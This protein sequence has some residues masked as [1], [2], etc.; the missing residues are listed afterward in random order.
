MGMSIAAQP[1]IYG[2][3]ASWF[4]IPGIALSF[5]EFENF[6]RQ[7]LRLTET[8]RWEVRA[9]ISNVLLGRNQHPTIG[10]SVVA[11]RMY[12]S[13]VLRKY[14]YCLEWQ[15]E[16]SD[17][18]RFLNVKIK[19]AGEQYPAYCA[20]GWVQFKINL[21]ELGRTVMA[22]QSLSQELVESF[23]GY[24]VFDDLQEAEYDCLAWSY[25]KSLARD[26][27]AWAGPEMGDYYDAFVAFVG[28]LITHKRAESFNVHL[29][30]KDGGVWLQVQVHRGGVRLA[31]FT[32]VAEFDEVLI[33]EKQ[34]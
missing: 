33:K 22:F 9:R 12:Q 17:T 3:S 19:E 11:E 18:Q 23:D 8:Q 26:V 16:S 13:G 15:D 31:G 20:F 10:D 30:P 28:Q 32:T 24:R 14:E 21:T 2:S 5:D 27:R 29:T 7:V 6:E 25:V 4:D 1:K 34:Q